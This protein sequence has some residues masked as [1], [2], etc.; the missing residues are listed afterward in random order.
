MKQ[1]RTTRRCAAPE[2]AETGAQGVRTRGPARPILAGV[3]ELDLF[4]RRSRTR[5]IYLL[6]H[7]RP[8]SVVGAGLLPDRSQPSLLL[9]NAGTSNSNAASVPVRSPAPGASI[10]VLPR[11]MRVAGAGRSSPGRREIVNRGCDESAD[12][13]IAAP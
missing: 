1:R 7:R 9:R 6:Y 5:W 8:D 13:A 4:R 10:P 11:A 2:V 3:R 12:A